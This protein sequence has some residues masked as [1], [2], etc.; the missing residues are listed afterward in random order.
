MQQKAKQLAAQQADQCGRPDPDSRRADFLVSPEEAAEFCSVPVETLMTHLRKRKIPGAFKAPGQ[1][2][3][4]Q[5]AQWLLPWQSVVAI[6]NQDQSSKAS[7]ERL[8]E[9]ASVLSTLKQLMAALSNERQQVSSATSQRRQ[10]EAQREEA[11]SRLSRL[12]AQL[13]AEKSRRQAAETRLSEL[14]D[15][16]TNGDKAH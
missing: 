2:A 15:T 5:P 11:V 6:R 13:E 4:P 3:G 1:V 14:A 7:G 10:A 16:K 8:D 12:E 9:L